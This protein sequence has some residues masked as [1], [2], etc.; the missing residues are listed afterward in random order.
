MFGIEA[1]VK[2]GFEGDVI[3]M[4]YG[5][6]GAL[7]GCANKRSRQCQEPLKRAEG[8]KATC[9]GPVVSVFKSLRG[10]LVKINQQS[11]AANFA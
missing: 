1:C 6:N 2:K 7:K 3:S 8:E 10:T 5:S 4:S 11:S 9:C